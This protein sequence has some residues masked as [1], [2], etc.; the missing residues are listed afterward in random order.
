[1]SLFAFV[2]SVVM[3]VTPPGDAPRPAVTAHVQRLLTAPDRNVRTLDRRVLAA[4]FDGARRSATFAQ[5]LDALDGSDVIAYIELTHDL[6]A[7][8]QGRLI[9]AAKTLERRYVRIQVRAAQAP[10][11]LIA[12]IGHELRHAVEIVDAPGVGDEASM[13][14]HYELVGAGRSHTWGFETRAAQDAGWRV[15]KELRKNA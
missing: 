15:R 14:R 13:R 5:L 10:D 11:E 4:L 9:L 12:V 2:T 6:P 1:M 7:T 3:A 8:T